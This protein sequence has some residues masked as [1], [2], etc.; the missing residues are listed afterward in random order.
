MKIMFAFILPCMILFGACK[1]E[2]PDATP[3]LKGKW[4][5]ETIINNYYENGVLVN[6]VTESGDEFVYNFAND[7]NLYIKK[8]IIRTV[9]PYTIQSDSK[10][11]LDGITFEIRGLTVSKVILLHKSNLTSGY[12]TEVSLILKR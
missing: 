4:V 7:G 1:K 12:Y 6:T 3:S 8:V 11:N 10:V 2:K 9:T 5:L